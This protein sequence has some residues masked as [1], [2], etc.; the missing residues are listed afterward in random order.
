MLANDE[1]RF[2]VKVLS[3][4]PENVS[5]RHGLI[6]SPACRYIALGESLATK[7]LFW[8]GASHHHRAQATS[9]KIISTVDK[10]EIKFEDPFSFF[11][12]GL[13]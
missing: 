10:R 13:H 1:I 4:L 3:S 5:H 11:K 9:P 8:S 6:K 7:L 12:D 2:K